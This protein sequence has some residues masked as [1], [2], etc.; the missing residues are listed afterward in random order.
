M[1]LRAGRRDWQSGSVRVVL[2]GPLRLDAEDGRSVPVGGVRL[3]MLLAR[4]ALDPGRFVPAAALVD[5]LWGEQ[6][7]ADAANA[8]QSLVSRLRRTI[9]DATGVADVVLSGPAG[10][11]LAVAAD[12]VDVTRFDQLAQD[13]RAHLRSGRAADADAVLTEALDLWQGPA[14]ADVADAPF[15]PSAAVRLAEARLAAAEDRCAAVLALGRPSD[16]LAQADR[17]IADHPLRERL[18]ALRMRAL[19]AV[20]RTADALAGYE[21]TRQAL[22]DELGVDPGVDLR[23][24]YLAV[25]RGQDARQ[26]PARPRT[27]LPAPLTSFVGRE[28][29]L[30]E[31]SALLRSGRLV[32]LVGAGGAG[33]TRM[34][35]ELAARDGRPGRVWF[36]ELASVR[37]G[38]GTADIVPAVLTALDLREVRLLDAQPRDPLDRLVEQFGGAPGLLVLDNCEHLVGGAAELADALLRRCPVLSVLA[39]TREPLAITGEASYR[40]GPLDLPAEDATLT[41]AAEAPA[42]R[43]FVDRAAAA[44][45][46]FTLAEDNL[47]PVIEICRR[48]DGL[49]LALELAAARLRAM[50]PQQVADLLDDRFRLLTVG[51]RTSL[52]RHRTLRGVV[53]WSWELLTKPERTLARRL[54]TLVGGADEESAVGVCADAD[55][56]AGDVPYLL[57]SLVEKSLLTVVPGPAR[58]RYRMLETVRAYGL[59]ELAGAG[60]ADRIGAAFV[61]HFLAFVERIEPELRGRD[62]LE[63]LE[64]LSAEHDNVIAAIDRAVALPAADLAARLVVGL[65]WYW[66]MLGNGTEATTWAKAVSG[67]PWSGGDTAAIAAVR[68]AM[69]VAELE[70]ATPLDEFDRLWAAGER[71]GMVERY[72]MVG[73]LEAVVRTRLGAP[74]RAVGAGSRLIASADP[75][76]SAAGHLVNCFVA[77]HQADVSHAEAELQAALTAFRELGERW[78]TAFTLG[79]LGQQR[80]MVGDQEGAVAAHEEAVRIAGEIGQYNNLPPM[81][82]MQLGAARGMAGDLDGAERDVRR[83]LD[84]VYA[85]DV[86]LRLMGLCVL[87]HVNVQRGDLVRAKEYVAETDGLIDS[88]HRNPT[89]RSVVAMSRSAIAL[90]EGDLSE[91]AVQLALAFDVS[92]ASPDMSTLAGVGERIAV[93]VARRGYMARAAVLLGA[94]A[95]IRG[96]LDQGEPNVRWLVGSLTELLGVDGYQA[97]FDEGF[98]AER[99]VAVEMLGAAVRA[100]G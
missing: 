19:A 55:L 41:D 79:L 99:G 30:A 69:L 11:Q 86:D 72:P 12:D 48:L 76:T 74:E 65:A 28:A 40:V 34:A 78:G 9:R 22:A 27:D 17:L 8:L 29:E 20:G 71:V 31:A 15:A 4:L 85:E 66:S 88:T 53:E 77:V 83:A 5:A 59:T 16:A 37:E 54:A 80:M 91:T 52:P 14:L 64:A 44:R 82:L 7:P 1:S 67:T 51:S 3:R 98:A 39:T 96:L 95:G 21:R 97:A 35:V 50:T 6:P 38:A 43:L 10:Y 89:L 13:G 24:A 70:E 90:A 62:Q 25:L 46:G 93:L 42:V 2:L 73:V 61:D 26:R 58:P 45:P 81:Q 100:A 92:V 32:S 33:K 75:W 68:L 47:R 63:A 84:T 23:D 87:V 56:P 94:A 36:V 49:P 57:A 18:V 60:E